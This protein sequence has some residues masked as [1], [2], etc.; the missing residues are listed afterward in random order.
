MRHRKIVQSTQVPAYHVCTLGLTES[1]HTDS[2]VGIQQVLQEAREK[3]AGRPMLGAAV[4]KDS[5]DYRGDTQIDMEDK[6]GPPAVFVPVVSTGPID[7]KEE[8]KEV[9]RRGSVTTDE[10]VPIV[11]KANEPMRTEN[12]ITKPRIRKKKA[13]RQ[14]FKQLNAVSYILGRGYVLEFIMYQG[15]DYFD[16][17]SLSSA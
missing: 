14:T 13:I 1:A 7:K 11:S 3:Q 6:T 5:F 17:G 12:E 2:M 4:M 15:S 9:L 8:A 10:P 16:A